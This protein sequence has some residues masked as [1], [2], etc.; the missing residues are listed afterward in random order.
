MRRKR[1]PR[2]RHG[3]SFAIILFLIA[4]PFASARA[5][6]GDG[7][8]RIGGDGGIGMATVDVSGTTRTEEP[9]TF[10]AFVDYSYG[11]HLTFG[12]EHY[13]TLV[14]DGGPSSAVGF[15]GLF[16]KYYPFLPRPQLL[17]V[18]DV[19][20]TSSIVRRGYSLYVGTGF[21]IGQSSLRALKAEQKGKGDSVGPYLS[22][23]LGVE[24][25]IRGRVGGFMESS[26]SQTGLGTGT[27]SFP[28]A[29]VGFF[30]FL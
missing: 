4:L 19:I 30:Y 7:R 9:G 20:D 1:I 28:R 6:R 12:A 29:T 17:P 14:D 21:G 26:F 22:L 16:A 11:T 18:D 5:D 3:F 10:A 15:T 25:P 23:K 8:V 24:F 2:Q 27:I 13:R